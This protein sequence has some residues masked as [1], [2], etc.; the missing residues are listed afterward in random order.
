MKKLVLVIMVS[1]FA[2]T[3]AFAGPK[4]CVKQNPQGKFICVASC[5]PN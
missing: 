5:S 2:M 1:M 4:K 3:S